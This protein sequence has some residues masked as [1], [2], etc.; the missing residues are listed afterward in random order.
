MT[1]LSGRDFCLVTLEFGEAFETYLMHEL[2]SYSNY[3][4]GEPLSYW[5][6]TSGFEVD[7]I[8]GDHTPI[9]VNAKENLSAQD[10]KPLQ[11]LAEEKKLKRYLCVSLEPRRRNGRIH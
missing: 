7:F 9:K 10:L 3:I 6:S 8:L 4:S 5:R 11:A 1:I 2:V